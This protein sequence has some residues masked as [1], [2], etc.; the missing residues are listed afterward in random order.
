MNTSAG[1]HISDSVP[2]FF[3]GRKISIDQQIFLWELLQYESECPSRVLIFKMEQEFGEISVSIR[4]I[5]RLRVLWGLNR[6]KGRP[7]NS[8]FSKYSSSQKNLVQVKPNLAFI[9]VSI[10]DDWMEHNEGFSGVMMLLN[11]AIEQYILNNPEEYFP[12][13]RHKDNTVLQ[14][15]KA[16]FYAPLF[17]IGKLT[18]IDVTE[19]SLE[20]IIS[21]TYQSSTL[22][23]YLAQMERID[24]SESLMPALLSGAPEGELGYIDGHM[25]PFW[26]KAVPMHKGKITMLGRI[27]PGSNAVVTH[28]ETG[29]P[30]YFDYY[31]PDIRLPRMIITYCENLTAMSGITMFIIDREVNSVEMAR[32]FDSRGWGLLSMLDSNQYKDLS[33]WETKLEGRLEDGSEVYSGKWKKEREDDPRTFVIVAKDDKLL[34]FWGNCEFGKRFS[35]SQWPELYTRRTELQENSFKRMIEHGKLNVNFGTKTIMTQDRHQERKIKITDENLSGIR[36]RKE[37]KLNDIVLQEDKVRESESKGHGKRL[38]QRQSHLT[39]MNNDLK[40]LEKKEKTAEKKK[41]ELGEPGQRADRDFRK[42]KIMT[43]RT[44][45]LEN[46]LMT[47][48]M[49]LLGNLDIK[50]GMET[51][52]SLLFKR[53]GIYIES[54][55]EIIYKISTRGL[56]VSYMDTLG[57]IAEGINAMNIERRNK[58][59]RVQLREAPT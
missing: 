2:N 50:F 29:N 41:K 33:D 48:F 1:N 54:C 30:V 39:I 7:R 31:P 17:G 15:F 32:E 13:L 58:P 9:G 57:K 8:D 56:S 6:D 14:R 45:L 46:A 11:Q 42:Q 34:P 20:N 36:T 19:H 52:I 38:K 25:I 22:N 12:L 18:E 24:A 53:S 27:M 26:S 3:N 28:N 21:R 23:Q 55:T 16:L 43:F 44:L 35:Y 4:H 59:I 49:A 40:E 5:N 47:F 37:K 10:F 51:L